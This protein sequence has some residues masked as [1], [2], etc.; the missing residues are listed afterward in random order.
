MW[1][2]GIFFIAEASSHRTC[3]PFSAVQRAVLFEQHFDETRTRQLRTSRFIY[4]ISRANIAPIRFSQP[5][6]QEEPLFVLWKSLR[7]IICS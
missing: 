1:P 7:R 5:F 4:F 2:E 6:F 3:V